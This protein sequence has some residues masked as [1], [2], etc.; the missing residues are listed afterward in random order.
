MDVFVEGE[1]AAA[2]AW[3]DINE[4]EK[5]AR[6]E[7]FMLLYPEMTDTI[8]EDIS[9]CIHRDKSV[10]I[11]RLP[12]GLYHVYDFCDNCDDL[13]YVD[14]EVKNGVFVGVSAHGMSI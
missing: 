8:W 11:N 4:E 12:D 13:F 5:K 6:H 7:E 1:P 14:M 2:Y 10:I 3:R 9:G